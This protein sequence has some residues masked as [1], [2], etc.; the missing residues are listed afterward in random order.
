VS[1]ALQRRRLTIPD[2]DTR[3]HD[4]VLGVSLSRSTI[5][6]FGQA[7]QIWKKKVQY[8]LLEE[9]N[10]L[11]ETAVGVTTQKYPRK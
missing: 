8:S 3:F 5:L 1:F 11:G 7:E 6:N 4:I 10:D 9:I 2:G